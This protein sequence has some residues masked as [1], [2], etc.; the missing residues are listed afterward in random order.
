[1]KTVR[2]R[3]EK[4][5]LGEA[6]YDPETHLYRMVL[7]WI[8]STSKN[9]KG[10]MYSEKLKRIIHFRRKIVQN[11]IDAIRDVWRRVEPKAPVCGIRM[12]MQLTIFRP[13]SVPEQKNG[14]WNRRR[15]D[16]NGAHHLICDALQADEAFRGIYEDDS[17]ITKLVVEERR[18]CTVPS[19][20]VE[21][22]PR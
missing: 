2:H 6:S 14:T 5:R 12:Q 21:V 15:G 13:F 3:K 18:D 20:L 7:H 1:M 10:S 17:Q 11:D 9:A 22:A 16:T 4:E 8:P 19:V